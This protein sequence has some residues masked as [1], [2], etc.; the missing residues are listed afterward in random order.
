VHKPQPQGTG[1]SNHHSGKNL[2]L[3]L[4]PILIRFAMDTKHWLYLTQNFE[5]PFKGLVGSAFKLKQ[6]CEKL[7]Y[8]RS[9]GIKNCATYFP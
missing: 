2:A 7:G 1:Q 6:A 5:S 8:Q 9:P 4:P 3:G